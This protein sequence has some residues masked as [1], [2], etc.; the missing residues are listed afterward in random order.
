MSYS[1]VS[2]GIEDLDELLYK[3]TTKVQILNYRF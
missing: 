3:R 2:A 1:M